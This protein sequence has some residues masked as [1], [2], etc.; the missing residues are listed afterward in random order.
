VLARP[1]LDHYLTLKMRQEFLLELGEI[2][3]LV[4]VIQRIRACRDSRDDKFLE[5][6][7]NGEADLILT[8][9]RDLLALN[10][11]RGISI[12]SPAEYLAKL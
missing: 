11:F 9:D 4:P 10:P 2:A 12:E 7:V 1:K 3:E 8:G 6:A 5:L